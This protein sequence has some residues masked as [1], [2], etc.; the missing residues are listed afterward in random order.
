MMKSKV[1]VVKTNPKT[2]LDDIDR[3]MS[4]AGVD[5]FLK[6]DV[7]TIL[8]INISWHVYYPACSTTP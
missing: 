4:L 1:A 6:K 7:P 3:V 8:K 2:V 5:D